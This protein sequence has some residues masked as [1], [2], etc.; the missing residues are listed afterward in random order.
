[1]AHMPIF[2]ISSFGSSATAWL[3]KNLSR[4]EKIIC[5][6]DYFLSQH[7]NS[8]EFFDYLHENAKSIGGVAG[9]IHCS[10][11][12][13]VVLRRAIR[14]VGGK[15]A[16]LLREP[17]KRVS[18]QITEKQS[19][20][21]SERALGL[22][23]EFQDKVPEL[24]RALET[25]LG[26]I[27]PHNMELINAAYKTIY[28]D[29]QLMAESSQSELFKFEEFTTN[30]S[31]LLGLVTHV[32]NNSASVNI[33]FIEEFLN[34]SA[35]NQHHK[36]PPPAAEVIFDAWDADSQLIFS[37]CML[38]CQE[39]YQSLSLYHSQAYLGLPRLNKTV[40]TAVERLLNSSNALG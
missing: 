8:N 27:N 35:I 37:F 11:A 4:H 26:S 1:M 17:I 15:F 22:K 13:G 3:A 28:F 20:S 25:G 36:A 29:T 39:R 19:W 6:H 12:H 40:T 14:S 38:Y 10:G 5:T 2:Y 18:S 31:S 32:T 24:V 9:A 21:N 30:V 23:T 34:S 33:K 16:G 7:K